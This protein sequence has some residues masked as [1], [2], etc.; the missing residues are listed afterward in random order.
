M[1]V[2]VLDSSGIP[3][4]GLA[5]SDFVIEE[6]GTEREV[7]RVEPATTPMQLAVLVDTSAAAAFATANIREGLEAFVSRLDEDHEIALVTFGNHPRILVESTTQIDRLRD[8]IGQIFAFPDT[9]AYLLDALVETTRGFERREAQ[10]PVIVA[11][12][13]DGIDYSS[14]SA[15]RALEG[16]RANQ[17]ATHVIVLQNQANAALRASAIGGGGEVADQLYQRDLMLEQGP[18]ETGG[19]RH[20]LLVSSALVDTLDRLA[21]I[22]TSQYDV[23]YSRP[24]SL[25]P[26]D[27]I[28][29]RMRRDDLSAHGTPVRQSGE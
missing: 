18:T 26:P 22:L 20:D 29:V 24:T 15:R 5:P 23:V 4:E 19:Q 2:S 14:Q 3:V 28:V 10:R 13:S 11:V 7:L 12:T 17:V 21:S 9:A 6:D 27:E 16:L 1:L 25:I 8:G